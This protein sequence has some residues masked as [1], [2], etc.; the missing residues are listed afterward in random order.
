MIY[1]FWELTNTRDPVLI[2][3]YGTSHV[4]EE[5]FKVI[6]D[7]LEKHDPSVVALE[8]D[9]PRL[10]SLLSDENQDGGPMF[11]QLIRYFQ[12]KV[13]SKTGVMPGEEMLYAYETALDE[14]RDV[15]LV[16]QDIRVTIQRLGD[17][18]RKEKVKAGFS[19]LVGFL[20]FGKKLD[21]SKIPEDEMIQELVEEMQEEFPG[22]YRVLME[23]R[24]RFIVEA[25]QE[26]DKNNEGDVVA[27]LGAA[28]VE[29]VKEMLD[30][31]D[32]QSTVEAR[33]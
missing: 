29:K 2:Y 31:V 19:V 8:L 13:G 33:F 26:V 14:G 15:A 20:G 10:N 6:D 25:L 22:L 16:D 30:E 17:V 7:A 3:V 9:H 5:S 32:N 24:N 12:N 28:H 18:R 21:V 11:A 27:F 23:E 1:N 4:S